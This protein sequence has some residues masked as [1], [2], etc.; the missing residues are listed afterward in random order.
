MKAGK[1]LF[2]MITAALV[3]LAISACAP[4]PTQEGT[5]GYIDDTVITTKVKTKLIGDKAIKSSEISVSTFK[6]RV[7]LGGFISSPQMASRAVTIAR[8]VPGVKA[9]TNNM[10]IK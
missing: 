2:S 5:G 7:Q 1:G 9:V 3:A 8:T 10:Q 4:S 6:G